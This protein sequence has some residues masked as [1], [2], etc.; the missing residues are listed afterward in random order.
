VETLSS[1]KMK[2][3][4]VKT[5][6]KLNLA[7]KLEIWSEIGTGMMSLFSAV[8]KDNGIMIPQ[9]LSNEMDH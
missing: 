3:R 2:E 5:R 4:G 8:L 9:K 6:M 1:G 7:P